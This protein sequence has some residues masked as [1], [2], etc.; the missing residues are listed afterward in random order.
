VLGQFL[1]MLGRAVRADAGDVASYL[2]VTS[3]GTGIGDSQGH[4]PVAFDVPEFLESLH[5]AET[6]V[7]QC[8]TVPLS[9]GCGRMM[10]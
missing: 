8:G 3:G 4:P 10:L 2:V 5:L 9:D 7:P 6:A 1:D